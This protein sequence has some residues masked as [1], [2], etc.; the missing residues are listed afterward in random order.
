MK[1]ESLAKLYLGDND[2]GLVIY[3]NERF[4]LTG[5][6]SKRPEECGSGPEMYTKINKMQN[7]IDKYLSNW[8]AWTEWTQC[9]ATCGEGQRNVFTFKL[10]QQNPTK[11]DFYTSDKKIYLIKKA[12]IGCIY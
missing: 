9:T 7:F 1:I 8:S 11:R 3:R 6:G 5:I 12:L 2:S 4:I 10:W